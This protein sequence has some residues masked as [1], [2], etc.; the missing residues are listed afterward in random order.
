MA[1]LIPEGW[2]IQKL[3]GK[4]H[5]LSGFPFQSA[6]F[7]DDSAGMG[8]I[9]IRDLAK[10][11]IETFY[12]GDFEDVYVVKKGDILIGMDGDFT[13]VKWD[14]KDALLNQRICK[15]KAESDSGFDTNFLFHSLAEDL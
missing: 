12:A 1:D 15:V 11:S 10:Q 13:I 14:A 2:S 6:L 9:R 3:D 8:I 7:C 4:V 5:I